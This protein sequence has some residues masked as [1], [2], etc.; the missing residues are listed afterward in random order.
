MLRGVCICLL[1]GFGS[2]HFFSS[3]HSLI[4]LRLTGSLIHGDDHMTVGLFTLG[5]GGNRSIALQ[6]GV[7]NAALIGIMGSMDTRRPVLTARLAMRL[8]R[9]MSASSR[10]AR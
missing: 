2:L 9:R 6:R 5:M 7:Q 1:F 3:F 10:R 8:A 4:F